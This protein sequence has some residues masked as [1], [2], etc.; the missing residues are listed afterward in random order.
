MSSTKGTQVGMYEGE[1]LAGWGR[2][3][4]RDQSAFSAKLLKSIRA[5][6]SREDRAAR[7]DSRASARKSRLT[8]HRWTTN[9]SKTGS[10]KLRENEEPTTHDVRCGQSPRVRVRG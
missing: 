2:M 1:I 7:D 5:L 3:P 8:R 6:P 9:F 4:D 10:D